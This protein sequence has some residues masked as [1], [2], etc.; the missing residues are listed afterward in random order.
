MLKL[1]TN[2]IVDLQIGYTFIYKD[3]VFEVHDIESFLRRK[4]FVI[5]VTDLNTNELHVMRQNGNS[6]RFRVH[7]LYTYFKKYHIDFN[8]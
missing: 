4:S 1:T 5:H 6:N 7:D 2:V 8:F 3:C